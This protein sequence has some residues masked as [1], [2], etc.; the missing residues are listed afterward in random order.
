MINDE[1][2]KKND[3]ARIEKFIPGQFCYPPSFIMNPYSSVV[4]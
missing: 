4:S 1:S 2:V 3:K